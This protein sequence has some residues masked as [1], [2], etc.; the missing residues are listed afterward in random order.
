MTKNF[1]LTLSVTI[2]GFMSA[3]TADQ[4]SESQFKFGAKAGYSLSSMKI[5]DN[6]IDSKSYFYA[7]FVGEMPVSSKVGIQAEVLYTQLGGTEHLPLVQL[8]GNEVTE[9]GDVAFDYQF[10]QI[11]IPVSVKYYFIPKLS[12]AVGMNFGFNFSEKLKTDG[13]VNGTDS[14]DLQDFKTL[15]LFPFL[16]AEYKLTDR[17]FVDARYNFNFFDM[18][19]NG[20]TTKI[21]FL[22]AGVGYRFN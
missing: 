7:G 14:Q 3:Q 10:S 1:F 20:F 19:K 21:G 5:F 12:A 11:Q 22:Q 16:G 15:N 9:L 13:I 2:S 6:K 4:G 18:H 17:F 8:I